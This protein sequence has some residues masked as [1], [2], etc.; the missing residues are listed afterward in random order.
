[1]NAESQQSTED[2][3]TYVLELARLNCALNECGPQ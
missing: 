1:M 3:H 2:I